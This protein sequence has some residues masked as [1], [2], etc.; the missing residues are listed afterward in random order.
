MVGRLGNETKSLQSRTSIPSVGLSP[1]AN[2]L[3]Y[4]SILHFL[5]V[6]PIIPPS[7]FNS[8]AVDPRQG[9]LPVGG[10]VATFLF[11]AK[12]LRHAY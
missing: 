2:F 11:L 1:Y 8:A 6:S 5:S 12:S 3:A 4:Y 10:L 7:Q 9:H